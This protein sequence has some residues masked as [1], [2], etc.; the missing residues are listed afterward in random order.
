MM[1]TRS[2]DENV[3]PASPLLASTLLE[4]ESNRRSEAKSEEPFQTGIKR[5][6]A[7]LPQTLWTGGKVIGIVS[8]GSKSMVRIDLA[9]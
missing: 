1:T 7:N 5:L 9:P 4:L 2:S 8:N 3:D 6:D